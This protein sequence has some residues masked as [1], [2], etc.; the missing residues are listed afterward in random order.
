MSDPASHERAR[1]K[2]L[3]TGHVQGVGYRAFARH[4]ALRRSLVGGVRNLDSGQVE[5]DVEGEKRPIEEFVRELK[6]GPPGARVQQVQV[7]WSP[8]S[9][10]FSDFQIWY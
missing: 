9:G 8:I 4:A 1:A 6:I 7:E 5:A 3:V 10:R 2:V